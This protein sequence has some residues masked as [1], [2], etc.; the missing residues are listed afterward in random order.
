LSQLFLK[1][2][3]ASRSSGQWSDNDF[4]ALADGKVVGRTIRGCPPQYA[5]RHAMV[6][7]GNRHRARDSQRD[8]RHAAT[9]DEAKARFRDNWT[10]VNAGGDPDQ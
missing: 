3:N 6:L 1:R 10:N 7:V 8:E 9:L 4:D 5:A 2:G